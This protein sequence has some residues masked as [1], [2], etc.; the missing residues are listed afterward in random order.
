MDNHG[1][2]RNDVDGHTVHVR[3]AL[4]ASVVIVR[5]IPLSL[6]ATAKDKQSTSDLST[7]PAIDSPN[8]S[9]SNLLLVFG[10]GALGLVLDTNKHDA[11][12][13]EESSTSSQDDSVWIPAF[14][15]G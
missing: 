10:P 4:V 3:N 14:V 1:V 13:S 2:C 6:L 9:A 11:N 5:I 12:I 8:K 7:S 15:P